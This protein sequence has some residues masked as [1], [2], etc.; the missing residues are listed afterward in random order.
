[1]R[2]ERFTDEEW[3]LVKMVPFQAFGMVAGADGEVDKAEA[4]ELFKRMTGGAMGYKDPLHKA[5]AMDIVGKDW[6]PLIKGSMDPAVAHPEKIKTL[7]REKLTFQEY[8]SFLGSIFIDVVNV[9]K[10]S[11]GGGVLK[12]KSPISEEEEKALQAIL[13]FYGIDMQAVKKAFE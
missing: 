12:K 5:V 13:V 6:G 4:E 7:L 8:Q 3:E 11:G 10:A 2:D 9:A 1:M